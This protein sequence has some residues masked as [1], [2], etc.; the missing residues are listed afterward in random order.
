MDEKEKRL[1]PLKDI[2]AALLEGADLPFNP[3]DARI[4]ELW[5]DVVGK[6]IA[7]HAQPAWIKKGRLRVHVSDPIW[8]QELEFVK[9]NIRE[10]LNVRLGREAVERIEFR[11]GTK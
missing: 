4:W 10:R 8:L 5:D 6:A 11:L 9:E 3:S 1:T 2:I 7:K